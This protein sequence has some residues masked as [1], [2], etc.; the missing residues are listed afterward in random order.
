MKVFIFLA[1]F[2]FPTNS[3]LAQKECKKCDIEKIGVIYDNIKNLNYS[4]VN[5]FLCTFDTICNNNVEFSE[6]SNEMLFKILETNPN[7]FLKAFDSLNKINKNLIIN[8]IENP[9]HDF[10][11]QKIYKNVQDVEYYNKIKKDILYSIEIAASKEYIKIK[12]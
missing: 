2:V 8:E 11:Y 5:D 3:L 10:N 1:F 7:L 4:I 9:I 6:L 12:K